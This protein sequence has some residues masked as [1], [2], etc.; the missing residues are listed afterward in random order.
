MRQKTQKDRAASMLI[1]II[2]C[3]L[4]LGFLMSSLFQ[5]ARIKSSQSGK[6]SADRQARYAAYAGIQVAFAKIQKASEN[7]GQLF[8]PHMASKSGLDTSSKAEVIKLE[9]KLEQNPNLSYKIQIVDDGPNRAK[10]YSQGFIGTDGVGISAFGANAY[11][12]S[13]VFN[14]ACFGYSS[15]ELSSSK[16][17]AYTS[18]GYGDNPHPRENDGKASVGSTEKVTLN[19]SDISGDVILA[20]G[21]AKTTISTLEKAAELLRK[22]EE[23]VEDWYQ[24]TGDTKFSGEKIIDNRER[25]KVNFLN[26]FGGEAT[27]VIDDSNIDT[28]IPPPPP[29]NLG[30]GQNN[31][32][33]GSGNEGPG[34]YEAVPT[35]T[36]GM[37]KSIFL[38]E[39]KTLKLT[40]GSYYI[41]EDL[42]L[43]KGANLIID[44][45]AKVRIFI[46]GDLQATAAD[47]NTPREFE[48][49]GQGTTEVKELK[50]FNP[51]SLCMFFLDE[52]KNADNLTETVPSKAKINNS[53][54]YCT[55][56]GKKLRATIEADTNLYGAINADKLVVENSTIHYD[57]NLKASNLS[58][59]TNWRLSDI[60]L[61]QTGLDLSEKNP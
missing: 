27:T 1:F 33:S 56:A 7:N 37:Y 61:A 42:V 10:I 46:G 53:K 32:D 17:V 12:P 31:D 5:S 13:D 26:P 15:T 18:S 51:D 3:A 49:P 24:E 59:Y 4:F 29:L 25:K 28:L 58:N 36:P 43:G 54:L 30:P 47:I 55:L 41:S 48:S 2:A 45:N 35:I 9:G 22:A 20:K 23:K 50:E 52:K 21:S 19:D 6:I 40:D 44:K 11:R 8:K 60:S 34:P 39:G 57:T 38:G 14:E 16:T